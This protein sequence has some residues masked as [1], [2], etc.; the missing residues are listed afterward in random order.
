MFTVWPAN[1]ELLRAIIKGSYD[2]SV[3]EKESTFVPLEDMWFEG[4]FAFE[5]LLDPA[6]YIRRRGEQLIIQKY[7]N[8][9]FF[10]EDC[11]FSLTRKRCIGKK[12]H[13]KE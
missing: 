1:L 10:K 9:H 3:L 4:Y 8:W 7:E 2:S 6:H 12:C 13:G 5:S 11:S